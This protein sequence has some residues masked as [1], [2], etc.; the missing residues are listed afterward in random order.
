MILEKERAYSLPLA[1]CSIRAVHVSM[2][3]DIQSS[4]PGWPSGY[5]TIADVTYN[6]LQSR[7]PLS[8]TVVWIGRGCSVVRLVASLAIAKRALWFGIWRRLGQW[9]L[10]FPLAPLPLSLASNTPFQ[11]PARR[12]RR[13]ATGGRQQEA[14]NR[15]Q[16]TGGRRRASS[17]AAEGGVQLA[18]SQVTQRKARLDD[19]RQQYDSVGSIWL[20]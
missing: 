4:I 10:P 3:T 7:E 1:S 19:W 5:S 12:D 15:R 6:Y 18:R 20:F 17:A 8:A 13:Q 16:A 14:G 2:R 9:E 11:L